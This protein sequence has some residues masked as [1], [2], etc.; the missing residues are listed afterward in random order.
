M[1]ATDNATLIA[2]TVGMDYEPVDASCESGV[3]SHEVSGGDSGPEY[4]RGR[5]V[6]SG[7]YGSYLTVSPSH[8]ILTIEVDGEEHEVWTERWFRSKLGV[9][10]LTEKIRKAIEAEMPENIEVVERKGK[11][12]KHFTLAETSVDAWVARIQA[13]H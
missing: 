12:K 2:K 4:V 7:G 3:R 8:L 13:R 10:R 5:R 6:V 1:T 9:K 11:Y